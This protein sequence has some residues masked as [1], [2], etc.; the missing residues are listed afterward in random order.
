MMPDSNRKSGRPP[1]VLV[2]DDEEVVTRAIRSFLEVETDYNVITYESPE[3]ALRAIERITPDV[4]IADFLMP[5]MNGLEFLAGVKTLYPDVPRIMLTGYADKES[6]IRAINEVGLFQ[7]LEKP[8]DN[9]QLRMVIDNAIA[10]KSLREALQDRVRELDSVLRD[11]ERLTRRDETLRE[12]L[13]LAR[14]IQQGMLPDSFP[15]GGRVAM[16]AEYQ[17]AFEVGGD[18]YDVI[19]L[20]EDS[21]AVLVADVTGHGIQA[22]LSTSV[23]KL[24]FSNYRNCACSAAD[25]LVG[26]NKTLLAALPRDTFAAAMVAVVDTKTCEC[27]IVNAGLPHPFFVQR[28]SGQIR[29]IGA[30]GLMIGF[31]E[32]SIYKPD[33]EH[34]VQLAPGDLLLIYTDGVGEV[35][36]DSGEQFDER[37]LAEHLSAQAQSDSATLFTG[38]LEAC[39]AFSRAEHQWDDITLFGIEGI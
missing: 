10:N 30:N 39:R 38:L 16:S 34:K 2:V 24:A 19:P 17:P 29:R 4:A 28:S 13:E 36:N 26:M 32:E 18:F 15:G 31:L 11:R 5:T 35:L 3:E 20:T 33:E 14:R 9:D 27:R 8:W 21:I 37:T 25:I 12:E 6:S 23:L 1:T 22:A 7:Y